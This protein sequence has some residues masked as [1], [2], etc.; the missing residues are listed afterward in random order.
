[1]RRGKAGS[2]RSSSFRATFK[3][4]TAVRMWSITHWETLCFV[5]KGS[6]ELSRFGHVLRVLKCERVSAGSF[7]CSHWLSPR[8]SPEEAWCVMC[9]CVSV[10]PSEWMP[11]THR[12]MQQKTRLTEIKHT[13]PPPV[14]GFQHDCDQTIF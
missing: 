4:E 7:E 2:I 14:L 10:C 1:M 6:I 8:D 9:V 13:R 12:A 11:L 3:M 5:N